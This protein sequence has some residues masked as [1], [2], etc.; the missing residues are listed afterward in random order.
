MGQ[1]TWSRKVTNSR[2]IK[3]I[4]GHFVVSFESLVVHQAFD[5][6]LGQFGCCMGTVRSDLL[7]SAHV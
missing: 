4:V 2:L 3:A 6:A 7:P 5:L 1:V